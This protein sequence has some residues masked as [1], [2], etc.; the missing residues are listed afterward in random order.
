M[1]SLSNIWSLVIS[2]AFPFSLLDTCIYNTKSTWKY[3]ILIVSAP[4]SS[5]KVYEAQVLCKVLGVYK[6]KWDIILALKEL[7]IQWVSIYRDNLNLI[8]ASAKIESCLIIV[9]NKIRE[10]GRNQG[11]RYRKYN[12]R[13]LCQGHKFGSKFLNWT[14]YINC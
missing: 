5:T 1:F 2:L 3:I 10:Q 7:T 12:S 8:I 11:E 9:T 6:E 14:F 13:H 4:L